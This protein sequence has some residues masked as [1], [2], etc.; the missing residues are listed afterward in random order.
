MGHTVDIARQAYEQA[1]F[2]DVLDLAF[3][4]GTNREFFHEGFPRVITALLET[5]ADAPFFG[6][7]VQ[8]HDFNFLASRN[9]LARVD[10]FLGPA[11][12]GNM[13]Q[14]FDARFQFNEGAIIGNV[15]NPTHE[16]GI[17]RV[18]GGNA[19]PRIGIQLF[20]AKRNALGFGIETNDLNLNGL[21][22]LQ[23]LAR[24]VNAPPGDIGDVQQAVDTA[25]IDE[26]AVIGDVLDD[27]IE[28]L[29]FRQVGDQLRP[30]FGAGFFQNGAARNNDVVAGTVHFQNLEGLGLAHQRRDITHR[31][32]IHLAA[33]QEGH[34]AGQIDNK[35]ALD[36][37]ED[38]AID[39][40]GG[41]EGL[42]QFGPGFLAAGFF[43]READH[44]VTVFI[45]FYEDID[46]IT[47]SDGR[48]LT[49]SG[50]F[51]KRD[52]A[53][54]FE[55]DVDD[56]GI[57]FDGN[58]RTGDDA[59]FETLTSFKTLFKEFRKIFIGKGSRLFGSSRVGRSHANAFLILKR[60][61]R[62]NRLFPV[63]FVR[64]R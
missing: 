42:L 11:H 41:I 24:V 52:A 25:E 36:A 3:D 45:A 27:A 19:L 64:F 1:E 16:L 60:S 6:I 20:H 48:L 61:I 56:G 57:V 12:L 30:G 5:E 38:N 58:H 62:A 46:G 10:V 44:T 8:H 53:F 63:V 39:P 26:S 13:D 28:D 23:G 18:F 32:D 51:F 55:A 40:F 14:T 54:R 9:N 59:S 15:G 37:A 22:D 50:E 35:A 34:G 2:G 33:R 7:G 4:F 17:H 31:P 43:A 47:G 21:A 49:G 29:A